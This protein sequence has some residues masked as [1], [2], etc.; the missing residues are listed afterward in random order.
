MHKC[1]MGID[2][3]KQG[4]VCVVNV[5]EGTVDLELLSNFDFKPTL[6]RDYVTQRE[7][8]FIYLE[9]AQA[10]PKQGVSS[11]FTYGTGF[12]RLIGWIEMV[13]IPYMLV[14]PHIWTK[15][16]HKGCNGANSKER[17]QQAVRRLFPQENFFVGNSKKIR[18]GFMD[19]R[20][21]CEYGRRI[22]K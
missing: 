1:V 3:G 15:E 12:G 9:K 4:A 16:M 10:M 7:V 8:N 17:S 20:L 14:S 21:I 2:P 18:E 13:E 6:F 19:A 5:N 11:M 22:Y